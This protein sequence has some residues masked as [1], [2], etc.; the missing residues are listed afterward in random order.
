VVRDDTGAS[1]FNTD[2]PTKTDFVV[3]I[4]NAV[5]YLASNPSLTGKSS[6]LPGEPVTLMAPPQAAVT[7]TRPDGTT[8]EVAASAQQ[9]IHY[10]RTRQVGVYKV[11]PA[12]AGHEAFAVNLFNAVES[13]IAPVKSLIVGAEGAKPQAASVEVNKPAWKYF[14]LALLGLLLLE[15]VVYN[16][17]V[18]V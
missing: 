5:Q 3:F 12:A 16:R 6:V 13:N 18:M 17:R 7:I 10:S 9:S 1:R 4:Q 11:Q 14:L 15:W 2:W 8:D